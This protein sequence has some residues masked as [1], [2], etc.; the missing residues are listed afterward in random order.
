ML[1]ETFQVFFRNA[2][3]NDLMKVDFLVQAAAKEK[4]AVAGLE[5]LFQEAEHLFS[6]FVHTGALKGCT[7]D[8]EHILQI[9]TAQIL[10]GKAHNLAQS[11]ADAASS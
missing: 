3:C 7:A 1:T 4:V 9:P 8:E 11:K 6:K 2:S 5:Y 10:L